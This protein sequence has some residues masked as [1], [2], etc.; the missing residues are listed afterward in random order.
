MVEVEAG[1]RSPN[2]SIPAYDYILVALVTIGAEVV[3]RLLVQ[4][5]FIYLKE[6]H[7]LGG[8]IAVML[9]MA[10]LVGCLRKFFILV[11]C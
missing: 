10:F 11:F 8:L 3:V 2:K 6:E 4:A 1:C 9:F 5:C 7:L